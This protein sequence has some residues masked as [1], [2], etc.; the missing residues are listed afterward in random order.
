M[1][2]RKIL[3]AFLMLH[4]PGVFLQGDLFIVREDNRQMQFNK[5]IS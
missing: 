3:G 2:G 4:S 1:M 5:L